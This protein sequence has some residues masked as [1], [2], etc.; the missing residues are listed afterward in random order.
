MPKHRKSR[1]GGFTTQLSNMINPGNPVF[2]QYDGAGKDCAGEVVRPGYMDMYSSKG[3]P[4]LS[5]GRR[6]SRRQRHSGGTALVPAYVEN[7]G[8][9][10]P[11]V[12]PVPA[13]AAPAPAPAQKGGRYEV[14]PGFYNSAAIGASSYAPIG[15]IPCEASATA[16]PTRGGKRR[17]RRRRTHGKTR[18]GV[19]MGEV[20]SMAYNAPTAG[21]RNDFQAFP[22]GGAVPGLM[23]QVPYDAR[24]GNP[25]C[26]TTG[27][28][29][30]KRSTRRVRFNGGS[31]ADNSAPV[32]ALTVDQVQTRT[33]FDGSNKG[34]PVKFGGARRSKRGSKRS[35]RS[36]SKRSKSGSKRRGRRSCFSLK[37]LF[38]L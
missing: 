12:V 4:G 2:Q 30:S 33:D 19:N 26:G 38:H 28:K 11:G 18:G 8:V 29:R 15:R 17:S 25:A 6:H 13:P 23:L 35:K 36:G 16:V 9:S 14:T 1:G 37:R 5:G 20:G 32:A 27:G 22:S 7:Y 31:L 10:A 21:Y 3:L 34:L 24:A